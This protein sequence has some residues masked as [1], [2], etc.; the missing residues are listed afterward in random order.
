MAVGD[1]GRAA[2]ARPP[3]GRMT[4]EK[5]GGRERER[6]R[7]MS[8]ARESLY[9]PVA[10]GDANRATD[11]FSAQWGREVGG[12]DE[13]KAVAVLPSLLPRFAYLR[14]WSAYKPHNSPSGDPY[15]TNFQI[16]N[17]SVAA[18]LRAS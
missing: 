7:Q 2:H 14:G 8:L 13:K 6:E 3:R 12:R 5:E 9:P 1:R 18:L 17:I 4:R 11:G 10:D 15:P 16:I